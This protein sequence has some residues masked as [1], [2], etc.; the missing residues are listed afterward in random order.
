MK[1]RALAVGAAIGVLASLVPACGKSGNGGTGGGSGTGG[2]GNT[3]GGTGTGGN[4]GGS[5]GSGGGG[6]TSS[7][8]P[9]NCPNGCC[10][11]NQCIPPNN[12]NRTNCGRMGMACAMCATG[13]SCSMGACTT[14]GQLP[15]IGDPCATDADCAGLGANHKCKLTTTRGDGVYEGGYCTKLCTMDTE[16]NNN[17]IDGGVEMN[18]G[19][20]VGLQPAYGEADQFCWDRCGGGAF[21]NCR[22]P[23]YSCYN[24]GTAA[25]P[26]PGCWLSPIPTPDA[27]PPSDKIGN[28]CTGV[29]E[30]SNPPDPQYAVCQLGFLRFAD[31]GTSTT[32]TGFTGGYCTAN[33]AADDNICGANGICLNNFPSMGTT[34]CAALCN[35]PNA[36]RANCRADYVCQGY[37]TGLAD[38]G[39]APSTDGFCNPACDAPGRG[40]NTD[41][42]F[43]CDGGYCVR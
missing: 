21:G 24:L 14:T 6:T 18:A 31:G 28:P 43:S 15:K 35:A 32:P 40:C 5:G 34:R 10:S 12:Q 39:T 25:M 17:L 41:A 22:S 20:C 8:T 7:C 23:G 4:T 13:Q 2:S 26:V 33:C 1:L 27:G 36:G 16:C 42:G 19:W 11:G 30:C 37:L 38:G 3:G 29:A 9:Q